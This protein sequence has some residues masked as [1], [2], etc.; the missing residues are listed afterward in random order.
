MNISERTRKIIW[1]KTGSRCAICRNLLVI[2]ETSLDGDSIV[3]DE[4]HIRS[5]KPTGPRFDPDFPMTMINSD[6]NLII[7]CKI[8]HKMIDDQFETYTAGLL[9]TIKKNHETWINSRLST[10]EPTKKVKL[11][12]YKNEIPK[13]LP[14]IENGKDLLDLSI[15]CMTM[16][17][18]YPSDLD[19]DETELV[20]AFIQSVMDWSDMGTS[21][22][23]GEIVRASK[24][25]SDDMNTI[26]M[27]NFEI[28]GAVEKQILRSSD[29][30]DTNWRAFH[31]QILRS[32]D[33]RIV[34]AVDRQK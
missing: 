7:L 19:A 22:E 9:L 17:H 30:E 14:R 20:A 23:P 33:P 29:M 18:D 2:D 28:F 31:I 34:S 24:S 4:C 11:V 27:N 8:H 26:R 16:Y 25:I 10:E 32:N 12:R 3:G 15:P 5:S 6:S 21:L 1:M 13:S